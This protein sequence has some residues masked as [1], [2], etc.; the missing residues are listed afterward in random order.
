M[1]SGAFSSTT[2]AADLGTSIL[3]RFIPTFDYAQEIMH[4]DP[5]P[6]APPP[7]KNRSGLRFSKDDPDAFQV[8][9]VRPGSPAAQA[10]IQA[11][12]RIVGVN[13]TSAARLAYFDLY[14]IVAGPPGTRVRL[15]IQRQGSTREATIVLR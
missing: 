10:G 8:I 7:S 3:S 14:N 6:N 4:L 1:T 12:D 9:S 15:R 2:Q 5:S 13:G 11:N